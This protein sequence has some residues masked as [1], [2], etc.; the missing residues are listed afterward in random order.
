MSRAQRIEELHAALAERVLVIDGAMGTAIQALDLTA[1]D[2]GGEAFE[3]CN[4]NLNLTRP[5]GIEA[6]HRAHLAAGADIIETNTFGSTDLVLA[7]YPP[8]EKSAHEI[9]L[10]AT[11]LARRVADEAATPER[12]RFVA[13]SMGP[14]TKAISVTGGVTFERLIE[15]FRDQALALIEGGA[16]YLLLETQQDTR[17]VKAGLIGIEQAFERAG[18]R[19]PVAVSGTIEPMG[20]MLGGQ[21]AEA[22]TVSLQHAGL[23]YIG[24]NCATGPDFMTDHLRAISELAQTYVACV[25]NA[26]LPDEDGHYLESP[27]MVAGVLERFV[28]EGWIN[29]VGGCCGT[30]EEHVAALHAMVAGAKP[31]TVPTLHR[32]LVSGLEMTEFEKS[33][34]PLLVGERTNSLGSR[35]FKR[36]IAEGKY[37]EASEIARK[38]VRGGAQII[39]LCLQDPDR[40]ELVDMRRFLDHVVRK[41]KVPLMIDSTDAAVVADA[42]TYSQGKSIIN[43]INLEDGLERF[44][45]VVPLARRFGAALIVGC[46]DEDKEQG[47]AVTRERKLEVAL[48]SHDLLVERYGVPPEDI[49]FDPLVFPCGTGDANYIGSARETIEGVSLIKAELPRCKTVLGVSNVSFGLPAAGREVLNSVFLYHCTRAGLDMAIVNTEKLERYASIPDD[50]KELA[51]RVLFHGEEADIAAFADHFRGRTA[52]APKDTVKLSLDERLADCIITGTKEG[53]IA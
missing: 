22:L 19:I 12:P 53:L 20:T 47:M 38:Q 7:E 10:A 40:D 25:P 6:I 8:L 24:L 39:D 43:S 31:R 2:F 37:E 41:V 27:A 50:E 30:T 33:N 35:R 45:Q 1:A 13:G 29:V 28:N 5:D 42:L 9:T 4:E 18:E 21:T 36:L 44:D 52:R 14:T 32:T 49:I 15:T 46:I 3:G 26:G 17:N 51:N 34:R 16:D 48:R 11:R 23:L